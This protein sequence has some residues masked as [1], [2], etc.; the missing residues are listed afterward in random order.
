MS[1]IRTLLAIFLISIA[2]PYTASAQFGKKPT[3]KQLL[4]ERIEL[5]KTIDSLRS[6]IEGGALEMSDTSQFEEVEAFTGI[7]Y[8][9][10]EVFADV[11]P[12]SNPDSLMSMWY[13]QKRLIL[14]CHLNNP[15]NQSLVE[16]GNASQ[17]SLFYFCFNSPMYLYVVVR[18]KSHTL[19][20]SLTFNCPA[21]YDG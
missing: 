14:G 16:T 15:K 21:L 20:S 2:V 6:I 9:D 4:Q 3:K 10:S 5:Q 8:I 1:Y 18:L 13:I 7:N 11:D 12:G 19:A 17:R